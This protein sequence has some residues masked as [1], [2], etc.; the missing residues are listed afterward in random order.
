MQFLTYRCRNE[1]IALDDVGLIVQSMP[2]I[3]IIVPARVLYLRESGRFGFRNGE[4]AHNIYGRGSKIKIICALV[5]GEDHNLE[6]QGPGGLGKVG[7]QNPGV[8]AAEHVVIRH[9]ESD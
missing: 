2:E 9:S 4:T 7:K 5:P 1:D 6:L 8:I 3:N